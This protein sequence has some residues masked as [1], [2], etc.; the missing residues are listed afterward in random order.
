V[1]GVDTSP[2]AT[3]TGHGGRSCLLASPE[4]SAVSARTLALVKEGNDG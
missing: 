3:V 1:P 4:L 2:R